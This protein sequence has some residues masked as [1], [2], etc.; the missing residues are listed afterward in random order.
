MRGSF[1]SSSRAFTGGGF[2]GK[3]AN[4]NTSNTREHKSGATL[5]HVQNTAN[6][7]DLSQSEHT[8]AKSSASTDDKNITRPV[9]FFLHF[10]PV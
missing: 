10:N 1:L 5:D 8:P 9:S 7:R 4:A 3:G 2:F 6:R